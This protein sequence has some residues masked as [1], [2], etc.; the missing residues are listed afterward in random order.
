MFNNLQQLVLG[1]TC[2]K[3]LVLSTLVVFS[4]LFFS[5]CNSSSP[6][7]GTQSTQTGQEQNVV[8]NPSDK[9]GDTTK[10]GSIS[11]INGQFYLQQAGGIPELIESLSVDLSV[12]IGQTVTVTGQYSGDTLFV[13]S[14]DID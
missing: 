5:A 14:V 4:A 12:Y 7:L 10:T 1:F 8:V 13:G 3:P 2:F 9:Q 11:Q 6:D